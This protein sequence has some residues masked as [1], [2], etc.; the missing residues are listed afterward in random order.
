MRTYT[1]WVKR[2]K[3]CAWVAVAKGLGVSEAAALEARYRTTHEFV[4]AE[5]D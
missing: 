4:C 3:G 2:V 5:L 1:V